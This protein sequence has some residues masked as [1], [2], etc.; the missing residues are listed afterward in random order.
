M[1]NVLTVR[2]TSC[3]NSGF[4]TTGN[5]H[6][7]NKMQQAYCL[8]VARLSVFISKDACYNCVKLLVF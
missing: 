6:K 5:I 1:H 7:A 8:L 3:T 4:L 2:I